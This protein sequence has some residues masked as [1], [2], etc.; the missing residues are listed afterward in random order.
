VSYRRIACLCAGAVETL[1]LLGAQEQIAGVSGFAFHP[2]C[3]RKEKP[4]VSGFSTANIDRILAVK[5]DLAIAFSHV[6]HEIVRDLVQAGVEVHVYNH[7]D[8]AGI[9]RMVRSLAALAERENEGRRLLADLNA[10][11]ETAREKAER[12][13]RR[14]RIFF[15]YMSEPLTT[16][17][18]WVSDLID[19]AGG[20]DCFA[21][22]A[23]NRSFRD[24]VVG[25]P[26]EVV[27]RAP[28]LILGN[29]RGRKIGP[30][31]IAQ[32]PGWDAIPAVRENRFVEI[33]TADFHVPGPGVITRGLKCLTSAIE[34][35]A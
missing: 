9:L 17:I 33:K 7:L 24:R 16:G 4:K 27:K 6:Q 32:R 5:P 20:E 19:I 29:W 34:D 13:K 28:E 35:W 31:Q 21:E 25:D 8:L 1:Y 3:A 30:R 2:P 11:I 18:G 22:I 23:K 15:E 14:P 26:A 12:P 10:Q